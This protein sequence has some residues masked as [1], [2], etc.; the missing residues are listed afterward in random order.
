MNAPAIVP[1]ELPEEIPEPITSADATSM[2]E[3]GT[4]ASVTQQGLTLII[5]A[6]GLIA[7]A[8]FYFVLRSDRAT[9]FLMRMYVIIILVFGTLLVVSSAYSEQQIAPVVGFFGTI[10]GYLLGRTDRP[11][12]PPISRSDSEQQEIGKSS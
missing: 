10:A 1:P 2:V 3:A 5:F 6:F 8:L 7:L 4:L 11:D 9:P 12:P